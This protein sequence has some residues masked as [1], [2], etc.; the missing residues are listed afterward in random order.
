MLI[1]IIAVNATCG[2]IFCHSVYM[3]LFK[4][5]IRNNAPFN[6]EF[7]FLFIKQSITNIIINEIDHKSIKFLNPGYLNIYESDMSQVQFYLTFVGQTQ[8]WM[9]YVYDMN[10]YLPQCL[11]NK[12]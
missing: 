8:M 5:S 7:L 3:L 12:M 2:Y 9:L 11:C 1:F 6:T 4:A 10:L